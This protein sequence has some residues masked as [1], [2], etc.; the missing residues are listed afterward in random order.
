MR[1]G[2]IVFTGIAILAFV[3]CGKKDG[4]PAGAT[5][6]PAASNSSTTVEAP[7]WKETQAKGSPDAYR[8]FRRKHPQSKQLTTFTADVECSQNLITSSSGYGTSASVSMRSLE[9]H[10]SA[11]PELS[12]EYYPGEAGAQSL[13]EQ[14]LK[15]GGI[16][17]KLNG[18]HL[19]VASVN[20][21]QRIVAVDM[22]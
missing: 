3:G 17:G 13:I 12:G 1:I 22:P 6:A 10:V 11:H 18:A 21:K 7:D 15:Q 4:Q 2:H 5:T 16:I 14:Y 9:V 20:N 8:D 19:L